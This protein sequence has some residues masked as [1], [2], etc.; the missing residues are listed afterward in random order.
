MAF[1]D[2]GLVTQHQ[3]RSIQDPWSKGVLASPPAKNS[4]SISAAP[5]L[6]VLLCTYRL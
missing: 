6:W 5:L 3:Q 4:T 1:E 2:A